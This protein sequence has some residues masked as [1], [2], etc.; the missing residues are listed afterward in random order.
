MHRWIFGVALGIAVVLGLGV[1]CGSGSE[2]DTTA[3]VT[4][5]QFVKSAEAVCAKRKEEWNAAGQA[6]ARKSKAEGDR[7]R[8]LSGFGE[9]SELLR[10]KL[11]PALQKE[12]QELEELDTPQ[13]DTVKIEK[14]LQHRAESIEKV[15]EKGL[16]ALYTTE[17]LGRFTSE[18]E[19]YGI[20]CP[21]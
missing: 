2:E 10:K 13:A 7:T 3:T 21:V 4:K 9:A 1:G 12:L 17:T 19:A 5:A 20:S 8:L 11:I 15:E 6:V 16:T 18:A 14:M